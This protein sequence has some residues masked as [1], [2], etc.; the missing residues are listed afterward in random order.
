[1]R[2]IRRSESHTGVGFPLISRSLDVWCLRVSISVS[3]WHLVTFY[4]PRSNTNIVSAILVEH[5][6]DDRQPIWYSGCCS[7]AGHRSISTYKLGLYCVEFNFFAI[8]IIRR[9]H[10]SSHF[11]SAQ[12]Y[13]RSRHGLPFLE[14]EIFW[15]HIN[16]QFPLTLVRS[17]T[18]ECVGSKM[19]LPNID[20]K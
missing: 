16:S 13:L 19:D 1:M 7:C 2:R 6:N 12:L 15:I 5:A 11:E 9:G 3:T 18:H 17:N 8:I 20:S 14:N 4:R 10:Y